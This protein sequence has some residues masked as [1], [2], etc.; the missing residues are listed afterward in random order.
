ML[1]VAWLMRLQRCRDVPHVVG[2]DCG[3]VGFSHFVL[4]CK[5]LYVAVD[6]VLANTC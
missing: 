2:R 5:A 3:S 4:S 1:R 6:L